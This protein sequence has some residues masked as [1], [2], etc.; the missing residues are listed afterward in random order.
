MEKWNDLVGKMHVVLEKLGT[1]DVP[2]CAGRSVCI[3][4]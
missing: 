3:S 2:V 4:I 1:V